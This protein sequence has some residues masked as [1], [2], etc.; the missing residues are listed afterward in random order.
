MDTRFNSYTVVAELMREILDELKGLRSDRS[1]YISTP[2]DLIHVPFTGPEIYLLHKS[3]IDAGGAS[4]ETYKSLLEKVAPILSNK[5]TRGF[6][7]D[8]LQK[9]SDKVQ[10]ITKENVKKIPDENDTEHR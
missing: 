3:F 8:S 10:Y 7:P 6:S 1:Y 2:K 9:A 4:N 5:S